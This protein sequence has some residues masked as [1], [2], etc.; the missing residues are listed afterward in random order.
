MTQ[1]GKDITNLVNEVNEA[2]KNSCVGIAFDKDSEGKNMINQF[3]FQVFLTILQ[4][5]C[6]KGIITADMKVSEPKEKWEDQDDNP[7]N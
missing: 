2:L 1:L 4:S 5:V 6:P 7:S 3:S